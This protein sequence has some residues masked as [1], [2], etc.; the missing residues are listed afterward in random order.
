[1]EYVGILLILVAAGLRLVG[2]HLAKPGPRPRTT[3]TMRAVHSVPPG[4][5]ALLMAAAGVFIF[6]TSISSR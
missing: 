3:A 4:A 6:V 1:M 2:Q 5:A